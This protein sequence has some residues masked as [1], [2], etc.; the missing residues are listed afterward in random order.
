LNT[1]W[2]NPIASKFLFK[3]S[4]HWRDRFTPMHGFLPAHICPV[5]AFEMNMAH[6]L[7]TLAALALIAVD[8]ADAMKAYTQGG[9]G[10]EQLCDDR[11]YRSVCTI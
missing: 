8:I 11:V 10:C 6:Y 9:L 1:S 4:G 7:A 5:S 2:F 3:Y